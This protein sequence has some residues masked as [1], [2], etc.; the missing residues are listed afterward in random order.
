[1]QQAT[2]KQT[3]Q[4]ESKVIQST[5]K[6][7][8]G[9]VIWVCGLA[10]A[11]KTTIAQKVFALLEQKYSNVIFLD[12]DEIREIFG[13]SGFSKEERLEV[14]R[15]IA[16]LCVFLSKSGLIVV[17]ATISLFDE[18][19]AFNRAHI[20]HYFEVFVECSMEE[21]LR[22]DKKSL[23]SKAQKGEI[24]DVMGI[25]LTY[26]TPNAHYVLQNNTADKLDSKVSELYEVV[27][28]FLM[29]R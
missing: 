23:Y 2:L 4:E 10:G 5:Q 25:D 13:R 27:E 12:G 20:S 3:T 1:M 7:Q 22:R 11:G 21:L 17:C 9:A 16:K 8:K 14:A 15:L 18:I 19:Y 28:K 6:S 26:D 29:Q 24:K